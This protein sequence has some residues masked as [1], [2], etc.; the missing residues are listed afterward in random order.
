MIAREEATSKEMLQVYDKAY[1]KFIGRLREITQKIETASP[2]TPPT[3]VMT[4][5]RAM[6]ESAVTELALLCEDIRPE[7]VDAVLSGQLA[8][9]Q[10]ANAATISLIAATIG[11]TEAELGG[12]G[13]SL[14]GFDRQ[15]LEI[16]VGGLQAKS[17]L[18]EVLAKFGPTL[19]E[20]LRDTMILGVAE[21]VGP[22]ELVR[23]MARVAT[24][25]PRTTLETIARTETLRAAREVQRQDYEDSDIVMG[26]Q[27][28]AAQDS[29]V[30]VGCLALSGKIYT[31]MEIMPSHP[32]CRCVM[33][34]II[35]SDDY[36]FGNA[37]DPKPVLRALGPDQMLAGLSDDEQLTILGPS[38]Y[39]LYKEGASLIDMVT[40]TESDKWGPRVNIVK[41]GD[42]GKLPREV[43]AVLTA[44]PKP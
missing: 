10:V 6:L 23:N 9:S 33:I 42:I 34:P 20:E 37:T 29:R 4:Y 31:T 19:A 32:N 13:V 36:L 8:A 17:P 38:R 24:D 11:K 40:V 41:L 26:Y 16:F 25:V 28:Q 39:K 43:D 21:E 7:L 27:R 22:M 30:C 35:P 3:T 14:G 1:Q 2:D 18:S 15:Q 5:T 44:P 12:L